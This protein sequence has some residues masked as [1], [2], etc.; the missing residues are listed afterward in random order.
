MPGQA[1]GI[2]FHGLQPLSLGAQG[3][4]HCLLSIL[5]PRRSNWVEQARFAT[6]KQV[7]VWE[8]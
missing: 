3:G 2:R 1:Q 6:G 7:M 5:R 4:Q 8:Q